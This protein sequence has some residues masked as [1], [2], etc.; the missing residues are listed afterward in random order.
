LL[1][2]IVTIFVLTILYS[3]T[4]RIYG[5]NYNV[6]VS[7]NK[8]NSLRHNVVRKEDLRMKNAMIKHRQKYSR[9]IKRI[10]KNNTKK[11]NKYIN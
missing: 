10:K 1:K 11:S 3:C 8:S 2:I 4:P 6:G 7:H 9:G 5:P